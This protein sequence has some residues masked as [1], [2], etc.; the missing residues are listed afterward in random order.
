MFVV[1]EGLDGA[2]KTT[3]MKELARRATE[4][5]RAHIVTR[6]PG[7]TPFGDAMREV[8]LSKEYQ[9]DPMAELLAF[10]SIRAQHVAHVIKPALARGEL[11]LCDR[12]TASTVAY[13][14]HGRGLDLTAI[15][16]LNY[17]ATDGIRPD[18]VVLLDVEPAVAA[19][20]R[21]GR[22]VDRIESEQAA[23]HDRVRDGFRLQLAAARRHDTPGLWIAAKP[24]ETPSETADQVWPWI[25]DA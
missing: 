7:G 6:E 12:F 20:R 2:G 5:G 17:F 11:V 10:A 21:N 15:Q 24:G 4:A 8:L 13:Q 18:I 22:E 3:L 25:A 16:S 14:G 19:Q 1:L 9:V 23:F